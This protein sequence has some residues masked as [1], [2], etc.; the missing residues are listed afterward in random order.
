MNGQKS[1]LDIDSIY[2]G[3]FTYSCFPKVLIF[4]EIVPRDKSKLIP[5][6]KVGAL[7]ML[8]ANSAGIMVDKKIAVKQIEILKRLI[9]QT[10]SY[11]LLLGQDMYERP[12]DI[13]EI[14]SGIG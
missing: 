4:P 10:Y 2:P 5:I 8:I 11:Q 14:L 13:S 3:R 12:E 9:Y 1:F 7:I 6:E